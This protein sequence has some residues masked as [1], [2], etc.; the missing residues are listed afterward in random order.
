VLTFGL[1]LSIVIHDQFV[2]IYLSLAM[3][4][5]LS[6]TEL[7][8]LS[9]ARLVG[10]YPAELDGLS[11]VKLIDPSPAE[12]VFLFQA[13]LVYPFRAGLVGPSLVGLIYLIQSYRVF[14][15]QARLSFLIPL[16]R[17]SL[18]QLSQQEPLSPLARVLKRVV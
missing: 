4:A 18:F 12:L 13:E 7:V 2:L 11:P 3:H 15:S 5:F 17:V 10:H 9:P 16:S 14:P 6:P 8:G 1:Q